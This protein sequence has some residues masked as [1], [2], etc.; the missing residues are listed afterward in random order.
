MVLMGFFGVRSGYI[1]YKMMEE[2]IKKQEQIV[3]TNS[4]LLM[5]IPKP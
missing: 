5:Q 3:K 4:E 1:I 2:T